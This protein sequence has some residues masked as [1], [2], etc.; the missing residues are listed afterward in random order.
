MSFS[1]YWIW[2]VKTI[3]TNLVGNYTVFSSQ[4]LNCHLFFYSK[5]LIVDKDSK[6][7]VQIV[8]KLSMELERKPLINS[9]NFLG[10]KLVKTLL[11]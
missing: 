8:V 1:F 6:N 5:V 10:C 4:Y 11:R 7:R 9:K 3:V 2:K